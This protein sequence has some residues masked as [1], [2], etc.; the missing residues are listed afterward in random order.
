MLKTYKHVDCS[1]TFLRSTRITAEI[2]EIPMHR[3]DGDDGNSNC[4]SHDSLFKS[5][6]N[7]SYDND[8]GYTSPQINKIND[9]SNYI[10]VSQMVDALNVLV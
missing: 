1:Q 2:K 3:L 6:N 8:A 10:A 7:P 4:M 5:F 9:N